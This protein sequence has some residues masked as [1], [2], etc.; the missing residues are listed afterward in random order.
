MFMA[1][2]EDKNLL[3]FAKHC[4][5]L[6]SSS[7]AS[8]FGTHSAILAKLWHV[9]HIFVL[10]LKQSQWFGFILLQSYKCVL[11]W[12]LGACRWHNYYMKLQ[13]AFCDIT[14]SPSRLLV[15]VQSWFC[16]WLDTCDTLYS[17]IILG[18]AGEFLRYDVA[19]EKFWLS[20]MLAQQPLKWTGVA[21]PGTWYPMDCDKVLHRNCKFKTSQPAGFCKTYSF[22]INGALFSWIV[23]NSHLLSPPK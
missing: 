22:H 15:C 10:C 3:A 14:C 16:K 8:S 20:L 23:Q 9:L 21:L 12:T 18:K 2:V 5:S 6:A 4:A 11:S 7:P 17:V 1:S 13:P 19:C